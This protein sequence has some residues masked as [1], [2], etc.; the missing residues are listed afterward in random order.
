MGRE[1]ADRIWPFVKTL[2]DENKTEILSIKCTILP[3]SN[4]INHISI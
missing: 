1:E 3:V 4:T 2:H